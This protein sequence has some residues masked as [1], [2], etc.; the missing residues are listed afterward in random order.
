MSKFSQPTIEELYQNGS[1]IQTDTSWYAFRDDANRQ[2]PGWEDGYADWCL[3]NIGYVPVRLMNVGENNQWGYPP[4]PACVQAL[5]GALPPDLKQWQIG[6]LND[7][8]PYEAVCGAT[9]ALKAV[10]DAIKP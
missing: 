3:Q 1:G 5:P 7:C 4:G 8:V 6:A 10:K 2:Y 9:A